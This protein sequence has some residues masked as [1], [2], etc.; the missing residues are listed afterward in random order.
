MIIS[1][2]QKIDQSDKSLK[3][4]YVLQILIVLRILFFTSFAL[5]I[6]SDTAADIK[7]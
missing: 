2:E 5:F 3:Y 4:D 1:K 6:S 7:F